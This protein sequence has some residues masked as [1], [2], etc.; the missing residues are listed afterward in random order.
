MLLSALPSTTT[1][2]PPP[3]LQPL[4]IPPPP[5]PQTDLSPVST[6][7]QS[8]ISSTHRSFRP[9]PSPPSLSPNI[10]GTL[11]SPIELRPKPFRFHRATNS[12]RDGKVGK[13]YA[14][15]PGGKALRATNKVVKPKQVS[16]IPSS[17]ALE[18]LGKENAA[19]T[20]PVGQ[21]DLPPPVLP[22]GL[23]RGDFERLESGGRVFE[24]AGDDGRGE[25][26]GVRVREGKRGQLSKY[27]EAVVGL[28]LKGL[29]LRGLEGR[30]EVN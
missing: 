18:R 4:H 15:K 17:I 10:A 3:Y 8:L 22:L 12:H 23:G 28:L 9:S 1:T 6:A 25:K 21:L 30:R 11:Q 29:R 19:P 2:F 16:S 5:F 26:D 7:L 13:C 20:T 24:K 14:T 27:D